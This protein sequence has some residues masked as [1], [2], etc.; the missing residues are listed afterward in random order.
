VPQQAEGDQ[1]DP[2]RSRGPGGGADR[3][4]LADR[5]SGFARD[6]EQEDDSHQTLAAVVRAAVQLI[7]GCDVGSISVVLSRTSVRSEASVEAACLPAEPR[8]WSLSRR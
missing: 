8:S 6:I 2:H 4:G 3:G 7:P 5:L 1:Q